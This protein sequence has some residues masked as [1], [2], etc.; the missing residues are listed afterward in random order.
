MTAL[1]RAYEEKIGLIVILLGKKPSA[2]AL[3]HARA[4]IQ[5]GK[6]T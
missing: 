6:N 2:Q 3:T 1:V 4:G 5:E